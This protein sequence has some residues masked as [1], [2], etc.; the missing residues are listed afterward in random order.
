MHKSLSTILSFFVL[1]LSTAQFNANA[2]ELCPVI[3]KNKPSIV[4]VGVQTPLA[5]PSNVLS[6]T[7][8]V[9]AN[10]QYVITNYHVV[11]DPLDDNVVQN[12]VVFSGTGKRPDIIQAEIIDIDKAHDLALLKIA[13]ALPALPLAEREFRSEGNQI[14]IT[15]FPI[16][17][18]IGLYP[19]TH[20][21]IIAAIAPDVIPTNNSK[22]LDIAM[23]SRLRSPFEVYQLDIT[24]FP[25]NSGSPMYA[26]SDGK[27][28]GVIN[29]V[30]VSGGREAALSTPSGIT[31]A[32]PIKHVYDLLNKNNV[33]L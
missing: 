23:L 9:V 20:R 8:F 3:Q 32:I 24:A 33:A 19:A 21:G 26:V 22:Q 17:A 2:C 29:K 6:G 12:R 7:G 15:G 14:L 10:G 31:Y 30:L 5:S 13:K 28:V 18:V 25:G 27:V 4:G 16:G 11:S 1:L